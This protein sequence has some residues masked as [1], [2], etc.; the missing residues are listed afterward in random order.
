MN[1]QRCNGWAKAKIT[2][3]LVYPRLFVP[4]AERARDKLH[5]NTPSIFRPKIPYFP[6]F[7]VEFHTKLK[8]VFKKILLIGAALFVSH[9]TIKLCYNK[10]LISFQFSLKTAA[11]WGK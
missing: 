11:N 10:Y 5:N 7:P 6:I 3:C 9:E 8:E 2:N 4:L 1:K